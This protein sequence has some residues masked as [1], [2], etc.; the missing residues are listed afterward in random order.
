MAIA[1]YR[2]VL[3]AEGQAGGPSQ[4][5]MAMAAAKLRE[6]EE[7]ERA[8][9]VSVSRL[10]RKGAQLRPLCGAAAAPQQPL[11]SRQE[12]C[13]YQRLCTLWGGQ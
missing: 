4:N 2:K 3:A 7:S 12:G 9:T 5:E 6:A 13:I 1:A 10:Q 8:H 11:K